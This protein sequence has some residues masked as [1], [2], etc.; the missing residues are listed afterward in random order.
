MS[1]AETSYH[2]DIATTFAWNISVAQAQNRSLAPFSRIESLP[3]ETFVL[4][5]RSLLFLVDTTAAWKLHIRIAKVVNVG[6]M[7][8][9]EIVKMLDA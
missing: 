5:L 9:Q 6:V 1:G 2:R 7:Q 8:F 3:T 4:R